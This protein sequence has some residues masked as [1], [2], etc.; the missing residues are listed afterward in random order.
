MAL[1][2]QT[3]LG[4]R[5]LCAIVALPL[6]GMSADRR[7]ERRFHLAVPMLIAAAGFAAFAICHCS[8]IAWC[9]T[10]PVA[11]FGANAAVARGWR[12]WTGWAA[13]RE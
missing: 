6:I 4:Q 1:H 5:L 2:E 10:S 9:C 8:S 11:E 13:T 3:V 7:R 12:S